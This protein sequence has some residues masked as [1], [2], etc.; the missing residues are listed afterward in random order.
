MLPG[1][2]TLFRP[3]PR[4]QRG[5]T[6]IEAIIS[7]GLIGFLAVTATMFWVKNMTLVQTVDADSN[8]IA[9]GRAVLERLAREIREIKVDPGSGSY[10]IS[11]MTASSLVFNKTVGST[12]TSGCGGASPTSANND[13]AVNVA[14]TS[15]TSTLNLGYA[16]TLA[17]AGLPT[18]A[19][20]TFASAFAI[21]YLNE[22]FV[23]TGITAAT[24]RFVQLDLTVRASNGIATTTRLLVGLRNQA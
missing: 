14:Y 11:T 6:L 9:D 22:S 24:V 2:S 20:T 7:A 5:F 18:R 17:P 21:T 23:A 15:G 19:L 13:L 10:C 8:A 12:V 16:G 4:A 1:P 3:P